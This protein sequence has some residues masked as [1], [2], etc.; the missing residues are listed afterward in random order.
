[1]SSGELH[2]R[3]LADVAAAIA[4]GEVSSLDVTRHTVERIA[5]LEPKLHA[6]AEVRA[7]AALAEAA[8]ADARRARGASLG[9]LH[10]VPVAVKDLCAMAGT[11]T[12]AGGRFSTGFAPDATATVVARLQDAGAIV[13]G[14]AELTEG[15]WGT[16]HPEVTPPVNPWAPDRWTGSSS[17]GS[18]V[19]V[20]AGMAYGAIGTDTAGSIRYPSACN[21]LVGLKPTWGRVSRHGVFPLSETFDHVGPMARTV[22]DVALMFA[23]IA[24]ADPLDPTSLT[25]PVGDP[26]AA[27]RSGTLAGVRI[28]VDEKY[29]LTNLD[30]ATESGMRTALGHLQAAGATLVEI[31]FPD[32]SAILEPAVLACFAEAAV[33]HA[34]TYPSEK[35]RYGASYAELLDLGRAAPAT[36]YASFAMRRRELRGRIARLFDHADL[37]A[38]PVMPIQAL[39]V[40]EMS[41]V[42]IGPPLAAAPF[43]V[44][45]IP[46]NIAGI[47]TLTL[48]MGRSPEG[49]PLGFQLV[50]PHLGENALL[51][52]GAAYER[53][54]GTATIGVAP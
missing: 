54:A 41:A 17:S 18:G 11:A 30:P 49:A 28:G 6:F 45:T 33:A 42:T 44:Y 14:K 47:P 9:V 4:A 10:G 13:V 38:V 5:R 37:L 39:T 21:Q 12:R 46:F 22:L 40:A 53:K 29:A 52:A 7:E 43:M 19:C 50:G 24:G 31:A 2:A 20:A 15:A 1:M 35:A 8:A 51:S 26:V 23:A 34:A 25:A 48:P 3:S 32:V 16:H 27:A 36:A